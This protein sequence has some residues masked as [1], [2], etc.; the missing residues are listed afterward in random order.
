MKEEDIMCRILIE[1]NGYTEIGYIRTVVKRAREIFIN[2]DITIVAQEV[3]KRYFSDMLPD[4]KLFTAEHSNNR[5]RLARQILRMRKL[6]FD[7]VILTTLDISPVLV[8]M[9]FMRTKVLL[10]NKWHQW[11][12][13]EIKDVWG[14]LKDMLKI[15]ITIPIFIYLLISAVFVL[16]RTRLRLISLNYCRERQ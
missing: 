2:P 11:W 4:M 3:R 16:S 9:L 15:L 1:D 6:G 8:S 12:S 5:Y 10:Y 7:R 13:L 14:Y